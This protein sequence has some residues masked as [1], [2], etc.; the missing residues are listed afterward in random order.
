MFF[1]REKASEE[2]SLEDFLLCAQV[3]RE[4]LIIKWDQWRKTQC[5]K[6]KENVSFSIASE[7]SYVYILSRQKFIKNG[8]SGEFLKSWSLRSNCVTRQV[9]SNRTKIGGK[10]LNRKIQMRHFE[11]FSNNV[12]RRKNMN[13]VV[14]GLQNWFST[15]LPGG[16]TSFLSWLG[17]EVEEAASLKESRRSSFVA[18]CLPLKLG[19]WVW[20]SLWSF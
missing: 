2:K 4:K 17:V 10:C 9:N 11:W 19:S 12:D 20:P 15:L 1:G 18:R 7:T 16:K 8:Q 6:I 5:F 14:F 3:M 13:E